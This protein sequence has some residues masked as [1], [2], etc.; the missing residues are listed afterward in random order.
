ME[1]TQ[2]LHRARQINPEGLA[3]VCGPV[4][5]SWREFH[6][7]VVRTAGRLRGLGVGPDTRVAIISMNSDRF[8]E[9]LYAVPWAGGVLVPINFRLQLE[10][11]AYIV[12]HA[13]A[14]VLLFEEQFCPLV[15]E[16]VRRI[17]R[18]RHA[19]VMDADRSALPGAVAYES[20]SAG[21]VRL[22]DCRRGGEDLAAIFY[23]GGT[24]GVPKG[25]MHTHDSLFQFVVTFLVCE[26]I[27]SSLV[28]LHVT[29]MFHMS[30]IG[31]L[32]T[33]AVAGTHVIL[34]KFD[35][36]EALQAIDEHAV[37]HCLSVPV[38][39]ERMLFHP[40]IDACHLSSLRMMG[41]GASPMPPRILEEA[42]RRFPRLQFAQAYGMT[43]APGPVYLAPEY[44]TQAAVDAGLTRAA[45][46]SVP[47]CEVRIVDADDREVDC[48]TVGEV[49]I[50]GP[51]LMKGYWKNPGLTQEVLRDGWLH[52]GDGGYMDEAGFIYITDRLKDMIISGGENVYSTEVEGIVSRHPAVAQCAVIGIP[53]DEWGESV[54]AIVILREG[55][56][57]DIDE[58]TAFCR[59]RMAAYKCP[60]SLEIR[61]EPLPMTAA[62]KVLKAKLREPYWAGRQR[63]I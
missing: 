12:D 14:E 9:C 1:L 62:G 39:F 45:G 10:E 18:L 8:V 59:G 47:T 55:M 40:D 23:T 49:V 30:C 25:V 3:I 2:S 57:A 32:V 19:V 7:S 60:R 35:P 29:P 48:G 22:P 28:H 27:D 44:H 41:Y 43:E 21:E 13:G 61:T 63:K 16:L 53:S 4:R 33:T 37:T 58:I 46:R 11:L 50:R 26:R 15:A 51:I 36:G 17:P 42:R 31:V 24:T 52:T 38:M 54:H 20:G 6:D 34:P 5:K 56:A